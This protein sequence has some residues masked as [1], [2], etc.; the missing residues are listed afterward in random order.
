M[1]AG[2]YFGTAGAA[3]GQEAI[4]AMREVGIDISVHHSKNADEFAGE[5]FD[6][7]LAV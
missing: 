2:T 4:M 7:P 6:F 5:P 3:Y 1:D